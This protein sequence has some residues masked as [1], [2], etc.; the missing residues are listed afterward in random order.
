MGKINSYSGVIGTDCWLVC[1][2]VGVTRSANS[3]YNDYDYHFWYRAS[4]GK[5]YNKHGWYA[6]PEEVVDIINP[7]SSQATNSPGWSLGSNVGF[8]SSN[9]IYYWVRES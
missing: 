4:N 5:W 1:M 2:R 6:S 3:N 9:T 8:Y 7:S